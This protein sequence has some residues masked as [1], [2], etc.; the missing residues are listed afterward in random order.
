MRV[1]LVLVHVV[2]LCKPVLTTPEMD[3]L[4]PPLLV[5]YEEGYRSDQDYEVEAC[6]GHCGYEPAIA[7]LVDHSYAV[8]KEEG[9]P[10]VSDISSCPKLEVGFE[11]INLLG[12]VHDEEQVG[13]VCILRLRE[14]VV[15]PSFIA[16]TFL[17]LCSNYEEGDHLP[18]TQPFQSPRS[19]CS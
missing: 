18:K 15:L 6:E 11:I 8:L 17:D 10:N 16:L 4:L 1:S 2:I 19:Y 13:N 9:L 3:V 12:V 7:Q 5:E 14:Q